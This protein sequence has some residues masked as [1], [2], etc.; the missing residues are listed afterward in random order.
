MN[1]R[2]VLVIEDNPVTRKMVRLTL[3]NEGFKVIEAGDGAEGLALASKTPPDLILQDLLL[4][5]M[6]GFELVGRLRALPNLVSVPIIAFSGFLSRLE[7]GRAAGIGF[8]DF[9]PKPVEPSRL[10]QVVRAHLPPDIVVQEKIG[11]GQRV[12]VVDD[13]PVQLKLARIRLTGLGWDVATATDG[14]EALELLQ[15]DDTEAVVSDVLM[16]RLDGFG[17]CAAM[18]K[19]PRFSRVPLILVSS[20][21]V[22]DADRRLAHRMGATAFVV[23][24]PDLAGVIEALNAAVNVP[25]DARIPSVHS[26]PGEHQ[27]H[28]ERILRQLE[29]Q[30]ALNVT[31][32]HQ[33]AMHASML[34]VV[35]GISE[36]LTKRHSLERSAPDILASLLE[37]SGV[38]MGALFVREARAGESGAAALDDL[39]L[40]AQLGLCGGVAQDARTFFGHRA[41]FERAVAVKAPIVVSSGIES[42]PEHNLLARAGMKSALIVPCVADDECLAVVLLASTARDLTETDWLPFARM[43]AVQMGQAF[44]L[45]RAFSRLEQEVLE[46]TQAESAVRHE[47]DRAQRYLD[48]AEVILLKLDQEGRIVLVNRYGCSMLGWTADELIGR[49]WFETCLPA[50]IRNESRTK[51][52]DL[53]G[54]DRSF[55]DGPVLTK[56][57][58]ERL[59]EWRNRLLRDDEGGVIGTFSSG[60]DIT[61]RN[62]AVEALRTAE[63]RMRFALKH[64]DVGIWD[65]DYTTGVL[66]WSEIIEAHYGLQPGTF[67]GTFEAFVERIHPGDRTSVLETVERAMTSGAD[68]SVLNRSIQPDGAVRWLS[69]AGRVL[70]GEHGEPVRAVGISRDVTERKHAEAEIQLQRMRVFK[71]TMRTVQDIVNNLL[72]GFLLLRVEDEGQLPAEMLTLVDRMIEEASVKLKSLG[73]LETVKEKEMVIGLG[74][75]YPGAAF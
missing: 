16:P 60:A 51:F 42:S 62:H 22:E 47:R 29:R 57:G 23:R 30:A 50:R 35:A 65:M 55:A 54:G 13:D 70:L 72:N 36:S 9:L 73:D 20:N 66:R 5:D 40:R 19:D 46:R 12:L 10:V 28:Y 15:R 14:V 17:L 11:A 48:T 59:I 61:E 63:E 33:S 58:D 49:D 64:A 34:S 8:T 21:Y 44:S 75:D 71:A 31:F 3:G 41:L 6:D 43:I 1:A 74:I 2:V 25:A 52:R 7:H 68:F 27:E 67:G 53:L 56:S 69:G 18:R 39:V 26:D 45:S 32:A 38:S 37:A 24:T 4:P